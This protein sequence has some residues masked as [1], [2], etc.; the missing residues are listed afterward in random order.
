[1]GWDGM[2]RQ[3]WQMMAKYGEQAVGRHMDSPAWGARVGL[4]SMNCIAAWQRVIVAHDACTK[5]GRGDPSACLGP[6]QHA[7]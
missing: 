5:P 2:V 4:P 7:A 6:Q 1:M 3:Q